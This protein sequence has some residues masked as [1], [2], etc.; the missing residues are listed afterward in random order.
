MNRLIVDSVLD[1]VKA[2]ASIPVSQGRFGDTQLLLKLKD[3]LDYAIFPL[4]IKAKGNHNEVRETVTSDSDGFITIP[5]RAYL[6][7]FSKLKH[8]QSGIFFNEVAEPEIE[9]APNSYYFIGDSAVVSGGG[10]QTFE[11]TYTL[12]PPELIKEVDAPKV[13]NFNPVTRQV[14]VDIGTFE[15]DMDIIKPNGYAR[16]LNIGRTLTTSSTVF[17]LD[18][19]AT[20]VIGDFVCPAGS[21]ALVPVPQEIIGY[22]ARV[23]TTMVL[24]DIPD[25]EGFKQSQ[26]IEADM[27]KN[28]LA[29]LVPRGRK[30]P[31]FVKKP[32]LQRSYNNKRR[33]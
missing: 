2:D 8:I 31:V 32:F 14:E 5:E 18:G 15:A 30:A 7:G 17:T 33:Y 29:A 16:V 28:I 22:V 13:V 3:V 25:P 19:T 4:L 24:Q 21:S 9:E 26:A 20:P 6:S 23:L 11:M 10:S 27:E 12:R 1:Q